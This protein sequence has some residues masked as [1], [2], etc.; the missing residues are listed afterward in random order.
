MKQRLIDANIFLQQ[1]KADIAEMEEIHFIMAAQAFTHDIQKQPTVDAIPIEYIKKK[2]KK[3]DSDINYAGYVGDEM[4]NQ[5]IYAKAWVEEVLL[6]GWEK[7]N[8][9]IPQRDKAD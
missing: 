7:E 1:I 5:L 6:K 8:G 3:L 2:L 4:L 9:K